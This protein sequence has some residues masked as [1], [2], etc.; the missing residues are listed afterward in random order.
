VEIR[1]VHLSDDLGD[2]TIAAIRQAV[3]E[4]KVVFFR[5]QQ[6]VDDEIQEAFS[7]RF[8]ELLKH[9]NVNAAGGSQA[10]LEL[11]EGYSA[12]VWHTDL[13]FM[14]N[15]AGFAILRPQ[16]LPP[17]GGDTLWANAAAAYDRLPTPLRCLAD[18][19]WAIHSSVFDFRGTFSDDYTG[20]MGE[21]LHKPPE[22]VFETEHPVVRVH[23][24]T[25]ERALVLGA[26]VKRFVG[27][28]NAD[29]QKLF[30]IFQGHITKPENTVRWHWKPGDLAI[31]DNRSTQHRSVPDYGDEARKLRRATVLGD[32]PIAIDGRL[33]RAVSDGVV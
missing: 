27:L 9:P 26:W 21:Y 30:E 32:V 10:L 14:P 16:V 23:P 15:P 18:E 3:V 24:E 22:H 19:L 13:T 5:D 25:G 33:S 4:H 2:A 29:S 12:S 20:Y 17:L 11:T 7:A 28:D 6:H 8:G 1:G 31:W